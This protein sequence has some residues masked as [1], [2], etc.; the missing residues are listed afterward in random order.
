[1]GRCV[2]SRNFIVE[3]AIARVGAQRQKIILL[4]YNLLYYVKGNPIGLFSLI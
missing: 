1:V 2:R 3:E 4:Y